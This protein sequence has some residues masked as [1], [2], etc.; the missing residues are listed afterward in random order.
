[1]DML[2]D[3]A[4]SEMLLIENFLSTGE[5]QAML[6]ELDFAPWRPSL[7]YMLQADG[8]RRDTLSPYRAS[9]TA[10]QKWFS[11]ELQA[12]VSAVE[13]RAEAL[14]G[15]DVLSLEYWQG[16]DY[17]VPSDICLAA[18]M[19]WRIEAFFSANVANE[20]FH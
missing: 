19:R 6:D 16:R 13:R 20:R 11:N 1:M 9:E 12:A 15:L 7:T 5:C 2:P 14:F 3:P 8:I 10:Q 18:L 17:P 4:A